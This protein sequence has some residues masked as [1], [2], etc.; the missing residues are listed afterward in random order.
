[1]GALLVVAYYPKTVN[2][3]ILE[4]LSIYG[5]PYAVALAAVYATLT[6]GIFAALRVVTRS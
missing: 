2:I 5:L 6:L 4:Y 1:M 3:L